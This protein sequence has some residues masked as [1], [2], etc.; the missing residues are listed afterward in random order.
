MSQTRNHRVRSFTL[1]PEANSG[2]DELC[3]LDD[4]KASRIVSNLVCDEMG[5][6]G[7]TY[8]HDLPEEKGKMKVKIIS[9]NKMLPQ[10][11]HEGQLFVEAV[12]GKPYEIMLE[13]RSSMRKLCVI[14]VDGANI[15]DGEEAGFN[16]RGYVIEAFSKFAIKGWYRTNEEAAAFEFSSPK[17]SYSGK[18][19]GTTKNVGVIGVAVFDEKPSVGGWTMTRGLNFNSRVYPNSTYTTY[20][21]NG[22]YSCDIQ[23]ISCNVEEPSSSV[24]RSVDVDVTSPRKRVK[25]PSGQARSASDTGTAYGSKVEFN[26]VTTTFDKEDKPS[27]VITI[28]YASKAKLKEWGVPVDPPKFD[29]EAFPKEKVGVKPPPGWEG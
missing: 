10:I 14:S 2:L 1:S 9:D 19:K 29:A 17:G 27:E 25:G 23:T 3:R 4:D 26:T 18:T 8:I 5:R 7:F 15:L 11:A 13:N 28:R 21:T 16:G 6:R 12:E 22:L 24:L 20:S